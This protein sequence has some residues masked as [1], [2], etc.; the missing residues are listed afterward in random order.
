MITLTQEELNKAYNIVNTNYKLG[1]LSPS[2]KEYSVNVSELSDR[3][4]LTPQTLEFKLHKFLVKDKWIL[5]TEISIIDEEL[6]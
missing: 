3:E 5:E 6:V 1:L 2:I 4:Y